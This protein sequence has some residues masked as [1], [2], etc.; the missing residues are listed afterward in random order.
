MAKRS[1]QHNYTDGGRTSI[2][3]SKGLPLLG[4]DN[5][6]DRSTIGA[7]M[8]S[9]RSEWRSS[10]PRAEPSRQGRI[11]SPSSPQAPAPSPFRMNLAAS[12]VVKC[13]WTCK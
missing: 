6:F 10:G 4:A 3:T 13:G 12:Q 9:G 8:G 5:R 11:H 1:H 2:S 7:K